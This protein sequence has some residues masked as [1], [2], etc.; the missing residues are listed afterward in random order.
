MKRSSSAP[1]LAEE[2]EDSKRIKRE[3][4][5]LENGPSSRE[6]LQLALTKVLE[7]QS[8]IKQDTYV[9]DKT[10][11]LDD[12]D[13]EEDIYK[14]VILK[15][16]K[17]LPGTSRSENSMIENA[18]KARHLELDAIQSKSIQLSGYDTCRRVAVDFMKNVVKYT[19]K[20]KNDDAGH[21]IYSRDDVR[22]SHYRRGRLLIENGNSSQLTTNQRQETL[23]SD[24]EI[25]M[26][27]LTGLDL[28][29]AIKQR[30]YTA[31]LMRY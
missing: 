11:D 28:H 26:R 30:D 13:N 18:I 25:R 21:S 14:E 15:V 5:S 10:S 31:R 1:C 24:Y 9:S 4:S 29:L 27:M 6:Y 22:T 20:V 17:D 3:E 7:L 19:P 2:T 16:F 8:Q 23:S 12:S